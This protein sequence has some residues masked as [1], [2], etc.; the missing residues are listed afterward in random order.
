MGG[1]DEGFTLSREARIYR[2][3]S[4]DIEKEFCWLKIESHYKKAVKLYFTTYFDAHGFNSIGMEYLVE[5]LGAIP[6]Q[7]AERNVLAEFLN[8]AFVRSTNFSLFSSKGKIRFDFMGDEDDADKSPMY[9]ESEILAVLLGTYH[10][11]DIN[12]EDYELV[13]TAR[14]RTKKSGD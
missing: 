13:L 14:P 11:P 6:F 12:V 4:D 7:I 10:N 1:G 8:R 2:K 5:V 9:L 3:I